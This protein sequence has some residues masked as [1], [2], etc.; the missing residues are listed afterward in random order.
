[1]NLAES[2]LEQS[3][4]QKALPGMP[5]SQFFSGLGGRLVGSNIR[6]VKVCDPPYDSIVALWQCDITGVKFA[7]F[8]SSGLRAITDKLFEEVKEHDTTGH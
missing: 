3:R 7:L 2:F 1:M 5:F 6:L 4:E 8:Y